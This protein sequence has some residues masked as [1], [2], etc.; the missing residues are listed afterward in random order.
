MIFRGNKILNIDTF[1]ILFLFNITTT[2]WQNKIN[3]FVLFSTQ[4]ELYVR[5][6]SW[7]CQAV[8]V[9][10]PGA[11]I[12]E[13][14]DIAPSMHVPTFISG[15]MRLQLESNPSALLSEQCYATL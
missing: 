3:I 8:N 10:V 1:R 9:E 6:P 5:K 11:Q 15:Q 13:V 2:S 7:I 12:R 4:Y 14:S